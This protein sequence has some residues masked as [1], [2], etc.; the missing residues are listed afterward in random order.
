VNTEIK[1]ATP[2]LPKTE[3]QMIIR[4]QQ[5]KGIS[6]TGSF[7]QQSSTLAGSQKAHDGYSSGVMAGAPS[8]FSQAP[9]SRQAFE[10]LRV[11]NYTLNNE[12]RIVRLQEIVAQAPRLQLK[13]T[14]N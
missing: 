6:T 2:P 7:K 14:L 9:A 4:D 5:R 12:E 3:M 8:Q 10:E 1:R 11:Q 13:V